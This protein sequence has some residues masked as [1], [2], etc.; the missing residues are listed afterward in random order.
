MPKVMDIDEIGDVYVLSREQWR[1]HTAKI[2]N[3]PAL[4]E[5]VKK[6]TWTYRDGAHPYLHSG[7]LNMYFHEFVLGFIYGADNID[8][9]QAEGNIIEH[10]DN[11]GLNCAYENLHIL[12]E[13]M[14]KAKAFCIDKMQEE[15]EDISFPA[16]ILD[17]YYLHG[18][19]QFQLQVC[20]NDDLFFNKETS[21]AAEIFICM[22]NQF[23]DLFLDWFYLL[24]CR[25]NRMFDITKFHASQVFAKDR[26]YIEVSEEERNSPFII[27]EGICYLNLDAKDSNGN[28]M[29]SVNHTARRKISDEA[30]M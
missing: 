17:V 24:K 12:S 16:F 21:K 19:K 11:D 10:L 6:Y 14:N 8:K 29:S 2:T 22:Y 28:P 23:D 18:R 20:M 13:D 7:K 26:P 25:E 1:G 4:L 15:A 9:M 27:R 5:E 30:N 3:D